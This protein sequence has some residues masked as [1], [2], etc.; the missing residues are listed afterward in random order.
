STGTGPRTSRAVSTGLGSEGDTIS[1]AMPC[2]SQL[3][4]PWVSRCTL[5]TKAGVS[6]GSAGL[7]IR[8]S[9]DMGARHAIAGKQAV[10][11]AGPTVSGKTRLDVETA[12]RLGARVVNADSMQVY[13]GLSVLTARPEPEDFA[14]VPH[15]LFGHVDPAVRYSTGAWLAEAHKQIEEAEVVNQPLVFVGGTGLY[16]DALTKGF[17]E[18]PPVPREVIQE[19]EAEVAPLDAAG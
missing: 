5:S 10:L 13:E 7:A 4:S 19:V 15:H 18:V 16:F 14:A 3:I 12:R 2:A 17:T 9:T 11:I 1:Q 6:T 8:Q